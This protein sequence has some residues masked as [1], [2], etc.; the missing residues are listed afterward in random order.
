[1]QRDVFIIMDIEYLKNRVKNSSRFYRWYHAFNYYRLRFSP[2]VRGKGNKIINKAFCRRLSFDIV[3][4]NNYI[5][6]GTGTVVTDTKI[7]IRGN[8][9]RLTIGYGSHFKKGELWFEDVN[10]EIYIGNKV[11]VEEAHIAVT[12]INRRIII[13]DDC[14]LSN[15]VTLRT[16]DSHCITDNSTGEKIN[17]EKDIVLEEHVWLGNGVTVLKGVTMGKNSIAGTKSLVTTDISSN[18]LCAGIPAKII[19][20]DINWDRKRFVHNSR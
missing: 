7:Y 5:E 13:G 20:T 18:C 6:I 11:S 9:H 17:Q 19:R 4:N 15:Q 14:M 16:G 12:G 8:N 3:G 2:S 10:N 1:M